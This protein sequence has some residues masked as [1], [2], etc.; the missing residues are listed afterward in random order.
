[1]SQLPPVSSSD[2]PPHDTLSDTRVSAVLRPPVIVTRDLPL[3]EVA[4]LLSDV[5]S[6]SADAFVVVVGARGEPLGLLTALHVMRLSQDHSRESLLDL[7]VPGDVVQPCPTVPP[8]ASVKW[9][10][11]M[12]TRSGEPAAVVVDPY[13]KT[14]GAVTARDLLRGLGYED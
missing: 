6:D 8:N 3:S 4:S 2:R 1:M 13:G 10:A 11:H 5:G 12:L 14:L 9:V 7:S